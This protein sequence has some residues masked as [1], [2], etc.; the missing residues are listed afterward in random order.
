MQNHA[1]DDHEA[2]EERGDDPDEHREDRGRQERQAA[3]KQLKCRG[4]GS[5]R[6]EVAPGPVG[7][8]Q[9]EAQHQTRRDEDFS[10]W[11]HHR[12][13]GDD[14][15]DNACPRIGGPP[16]LRELLL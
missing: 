12:D 15:E 11:R 8:G 14:N 4:R 2:Q 13:T 7:G 1:V 10:P 6:A 16:G 5:Q 3:R 9:E